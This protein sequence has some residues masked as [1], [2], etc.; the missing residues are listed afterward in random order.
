MSWY[1][2]NYRN[3]KKSLGFWDGSS[4]FPQITI[5][6]KPKVGAWDKLKSFPIKTVS[7]IL[8]LLPKDKELS[9]LAT[10]EELAKYRTDWYGSQIYAPEG[11]EGNRH[12]TIAWVH[13]DTQLILAT[14]YIDEWLFKAVAQYFDEAFEQ[15]QIQ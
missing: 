15:I 10:E 13:F 5:G 8:N 1:N 9:W 14:V 11:W 3:N 2:K 12:G 7:K 4:L 6:V